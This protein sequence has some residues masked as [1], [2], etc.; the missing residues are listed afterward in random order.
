MPPAAVGLVDASSFCNFTIGAGTVELGM[1]GANAPAD[2][3]LISWVGLAPWVHFAFFARFVSALPLPA[4]L[5]DV[6]VTSLSLVPTAA[7]AFSVIFG[8]CFTVLEKKFGCMLGTLVWEEWEAQ[9]HMMFCFSTL[10]QLHSFH[11]Y[12][13]DAIAIAWYLLNP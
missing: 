6:V 9:H 2:E 3:S 13:D 7:L 5:F 10:T 12:L 8:T 4:F 1:S 11:P